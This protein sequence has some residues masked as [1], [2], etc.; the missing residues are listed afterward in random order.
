MQRINRDK[1]ANTVLY[2]LKACTARRPG[3]IAL[4]KLVWYVDYWHYRRH[5]CTVTDGDYVAL[6]NGPALDRY[7]D[8]FAELVTKQVLDVEQVPIFG[9]PKPKTQYTAKMGADESQFSETE[10][11][12][13]ND[14]VRELGHLSGKELIERTHNEGPW[15]L[16][17]RDSQ[18]SPPIPASTFRWL[19]NLP[20]EDDLVRFRADVD[21]PQVRAAL[22]R[23]RTAP[24]PS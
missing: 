22:E 14:V 23:L 2:L 9:Q 19:D 20:T 11:Q 3:L 12:V 13:L 18:N 7:E 16:M 4:V 10:L 15:P 17:D 21:R 5:L 1:F 24:S 8:L 6:P